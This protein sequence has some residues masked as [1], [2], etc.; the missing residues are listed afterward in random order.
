MKSTVM[1]RTENGLKSEFRSCLHFFLCRLGQVT[2]LS[3][4]H[5]PLHMRGWILE[6]LTH[7]DN[8][9]LVSFPLGLALKHLLSEF[10][11]SGGRTLGEHQQGLFH[12]KGKKGSVQTVLE[13]FF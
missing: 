13:R 8:Q 2:Y 12:R 9:I 6:Y 5:V 7:T 4:L 3:E 1:L 11:N 10:K